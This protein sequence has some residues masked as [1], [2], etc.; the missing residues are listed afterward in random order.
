MDLVGEIVWDRVPLD[1][2]LPQMLLEPRMLHSTSADGI[3]G[4][5]IDVK[6]AL[7]KR[8]Y[9]ENSTL[10]FEVTDELCPWNT[11][12]W[13]LKT[14]PEESSVH[15]TDNTPQLKIPASTLSMLIF[16]QISATEA[17]RMERLEAVDPKALPIWDKTMHTI[18]KPF[19]GDIF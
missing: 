10:V 5:I 13:Q 1:D 2:P 15:R 9:P 4:R 8:P 3:L 11:G 16:G 12:R 19:C 14:S 7:T 17:S 18:H 6:Q